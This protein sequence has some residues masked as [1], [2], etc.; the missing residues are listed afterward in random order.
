[1]TELEIRPVKEILLE[2][3]TTINT[4]IKLVACRIKN[5]KDLDQIDRVKKRLNLIR[6]MAD[7]ELIIRV[8][9]AFFMRYKELIETKQLDKLIDLNPSEECVNIGIKLDATDSYMFS[10]FD[11]IRPHI[12]SMKPSEKMLIADDILKLYSNY[13]EYILSK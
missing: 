2:F 1:M 11:N 13:L 4:L 10:L 7:P 9:G 8:S 12:K 6:G 3:N 5:P